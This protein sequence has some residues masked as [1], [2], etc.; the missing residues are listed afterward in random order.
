M[1]NIY[2]LGRW[3]KAGMRRLALIPL[4]LLITPPPIHAAPDPAFTQFI[5]SLWRFERDVR[6]RN[7][8]P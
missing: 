3:F 2:G 5:A 8:R 4:V 1:I 6:S 7:E